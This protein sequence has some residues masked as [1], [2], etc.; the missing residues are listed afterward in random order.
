ME[1]SFRIN[2][3]KKTK[4]QKKYFKTSKGA[5]ITSI[6]MAVTFFAFTIAFSVYS[7]GMKNTFLVQNITASDYG[8]KNLLVIWSVL[9]AVDIIILFLWVIQKMVVFIIY[10][11]Y[12]GQRI[13][14]SL[15]ISA[16]AIEY[17]YQNLVG[18]TASDR[19]IVRVPVDSIR[20]IKIDKK[21]D[22]IEI[23]GL[24]SSKYYENYAR[25]ET[26]APKNN[27]KEGSLV[28][29]DYF[30]PGLIEFFKENYAETAETK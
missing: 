25:K 21:I 10:G 11:K 23:C 26:R 9:I 17:G 20:R 5:M 24:V 29:F 2:E 16:D 15:T 18:S 27:Y 14:E 3:L 22:R 6:G 7:F 8:E 1:K 12:I 30:E 19:V 28:L 13:N 4:V